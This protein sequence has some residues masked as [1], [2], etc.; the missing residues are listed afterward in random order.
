MSLAIVSTKHR[1]PRPAVEPSEGVDTKSP[2]NVATAI[3][4][5]F[6]SLG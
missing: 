4:L 1:S 2:E 5:N 3:T 6:Y